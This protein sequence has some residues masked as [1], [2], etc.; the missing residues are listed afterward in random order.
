MNV[1]FSGSTMMTGVTATSLQ[2]QVARLL[3]VGLVSR[4]CYYTGWII[5]HFG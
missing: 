1:L 2:T 3:G 4:P 5:G